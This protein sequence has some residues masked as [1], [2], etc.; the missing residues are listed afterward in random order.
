MDSPISIAKVNKLLEYS[1]T[2]ISYYNK[3]FNRISPRISYEHFSSI[4]LL[5]TYTAH[6]NE[7]NLS[8]EPKQGDE[9]EILMGVLGLPLKIVRSNLESTRLAMQLTL[10][11]R[12]HL[13]GL[14]QRLKIAVFS[15][16]I[17]EI[18]KYNVRSDLLEFSLREIND[19]ALEMQMKA[20]VKHKSQ[21]LIGPP[22]IIARLAKICSESK[23]ETKNLE[24][25][26][27][28]SE[29]MNYK[30]R[31]AIEGVF[32]C[33]VTNVFGNHEQWVIG[34][35]CKEKSIHIAD[36]QVMVNIVDS[37]G[38]TLPYGASG[39]VIMTGLN[40]YSMPLIRYKLGI[41][42]VLYPSSYCNCKRNSP[43]IKFPNYKNYDW[44]TTERGLTSPSSFTNLFRGISG[45]EYSDIRKINL[46]QKSTR[47][48]EFI[49]FSEE[50]K[51]YDVDKLKPI[52]VAISK[53]INDSFDISFRIKKPEE[54][55]HD[56]RW[57]LNQI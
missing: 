51:L 27:T 39:E 47:G 16:S 21:I 6:K 49:I 17:K 34:Y 8:L 7:Y 50:K 11:R 54:M 36:E 15:A 5:D 45:P 28:R 18:V 4:P 30:Q 14:P 2:N 23:L 43:V 31:Q 24:L 10:E 1:Q 42:G 53:V 12:K 41:T 48:F 44:I 46:I 38:R 22:S 40:N 19:E 52:L 9:N 33:P 20:I 35:S 56:R 13:Q 37:S 32:N 57:F 26:E 3:I 55:G 29:I 25:I